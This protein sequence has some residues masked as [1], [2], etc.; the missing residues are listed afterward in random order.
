MKKIIL[1][2]ALLL[3]IA[4]G[5]GCSQTEV[6]EIEM[7]Q[8]TNKLPVYL[9]AG[10]YQLNFVYGD[11]GWGFDIIEGENV[12]F[13]NPT[14]AVIMTIS[15]KKEDLV[16]TANPYDT[17]VVEDGVV[18]CTAQ[19]TTEK[20]ASFLVRD[21]YYVEN[22]A[23]LVDRIVTVTG[24]TGDEKG[25]ASVYQVIDP[26][27]GGRDDYE[28]FIPSIIYKDSETLSSS[29]IMSNLTDV[30]YVKETRCG[31]PLAMLR[32]KTDGYSIGLVHVNPK[33]S[34]EKN[35]YKQSLVKDNSQ[36]YGS[37][38]F[39]LKA[40]KEYPISVD[41]VY[42]A[43]ET[44]VSYEVGGTTRRYHEITTGTSHAYTLGLIPQKSSIYNEAM[45]DTYLSAISLEDIE[46]AQVDLDQV[47]ALNMELY[48]KLYVEYS[49]ADGKYSAGLPFAVNVKDLDD[50]YAVSFQMG[51]I[52]AQ[53][54]IAA[55]LIRDGVQNS[56]EKLLTMGQK[57][58]NFWTAEHVYN[59]VLPPSWWQPSNDETAGSSTGYPSFL[60]CFV[61]GAEGILN[62]CIYG[63]E[64]GLDYSSWEN[65]V[66][67]I[68]DFLVDNQNSDGSYYRA[69][70]VDG[71][72]CTDTSSAA[73]QGTSKLNTPVAVRFLCSMYDYTKDNKYYDAAV[74][75]ADYC[76]EELYLRLGKYVGGTPDNPNVPDKEAA[77]YALYAFS[78][79]YDMTGDEKYY[80][81]VEHAAV[82]AM[83]WVYT[84]DF[85]VAYSSTMIYDSL[86]IFKE[87]N[88]A[89]WSLIATGHS[90]IDVF[91]ATAYFE[92][93]QQYVR[94][95]DEAYLKLA[96]L[97]MNNTKQAMDLEGEWGYLYQGFALEA[98]NVADHIF[99]T[100]ENGVWLPWISAAYVEPMLQMKNTFG[101]YDIYEAIEQ[102]SREELLE[103]IK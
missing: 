92:I 53:T 101:T 63:K 80:A 44:P 88:T 76:Y 74:K 47:Y 86:N 20:G 41:F 58:L 51:F 91:G 65:A 22:D 72:V 57:I 23:F 46:I 35:K 4:V 59:N 85:S 3:L 25:F 43:T 7:S 94:S 17:V 33:I 13:L 87:G 78:A 55:E 34:C 32:S 27:G 77:I 38:G 2:F 79:V 12:L 75:A 11:H 26:D 68:A 6:E 45:V 39:T 71:T 60:R 66:V 14:P 15:N 49:G 99:Y 31:T 93:F 84:Y 95:G 29:A 98:C 48:E 102:Y 83:S 30:N 70:N 54:A 52:G 1:L 5:T 100:A 96:G 82:S 42:P 81:A 90:A 19:V 61:D 37:L 40:E 69:Y 50:F 97:L 73:Y 21:R 8:E 28:Y 36:Q 56:N 89:G 10:N 67:K 64:V 18:V 103:M 62:A 9:D 16:T 24:N